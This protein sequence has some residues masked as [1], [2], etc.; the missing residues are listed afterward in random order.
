MIDYVQHTTPHAKIET[1]R[2]KEWAGVKLVPRV[3]FLFIF[4]FLGAST[5]Q[6]VQR[7]LTFNVPQTGFGGHLYS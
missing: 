6:T 2:F 1:R 3:L 7:G 4:S 5:E